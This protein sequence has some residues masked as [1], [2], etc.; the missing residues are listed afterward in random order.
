MVR[1]SAFLYGNQ[2][3]F[4]G[5]AGHDRVRQGVRCQGSRASK[6]PVAEG[7]GRDRSDHGR[8][9]QIAEAGRLHDRLQAGRDV[10][11][12]V[13]RHGGADR[14]AGESW[15][16]V[17]K[18]SLAMIAVPRRSASPDVRRRRT[19]C[20]GRTCRSTATPSTGRL[21]GHRRPVGQQLVEL[22]LRLGPLDLQLLEL[23]AVL[24]QGQ[25]SVI[26]VPAAFDHG[27]LGGVAAAFFLPR[28]A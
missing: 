21:D 10:L 18:T 20:R 16:T 24:A 12:L 8:Q 3:H 7:N 22:L 28:R 11:H 17:M 26:L 9:L 6:P 23:Q 13:L 25:G 1:A 14:P 15:T 2:L 19:T 27:P 4:A 5:H